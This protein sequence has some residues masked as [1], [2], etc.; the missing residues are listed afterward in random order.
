MV[1]MSDVNEELVEQE[2]LHRRCDRRSPRRQRPVPSSRWRP[3]TPLLAAGA[4]S[5]IAGGLAAAV[6]GPTGWEHG[7]WVAA[8]LVLVAGVAQISLAV[9]PV[10]LT[11]T[12]ATARVAAVECALWNAGCL[13]VIAGTLVSNP[14]A[15][16]IGSAPLVATL[17]ISF[18]AVH[19]PV[20]HPRLAFAYRALIIVLLASIP[21]GVA[22]AWIRR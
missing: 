20:G 18:L 14:V 5:I 17:A 6:T 21:V 7:S 12:P 16:T 3:S 22:L 15:V 8:F 11:T 19:V 13:T 10:E 2:Y 4:V 1:I 9:A